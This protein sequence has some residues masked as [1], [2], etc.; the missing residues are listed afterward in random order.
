MDIQGDLYMFDEFQTSRKARTRRP[1]VSRAYMCTQCSHNVANLLQV[2][3]LYDV[4][5]NIRDDESEHV[6]TMRACQL[7]DKL[8]KRCDLKHAIW[9]LGMMYDAH[10]NFRECAS[11]PNSAAAYA[12]W[13]EEFEDGDD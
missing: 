10:T 9:I 5:C 1:E 12:Q 6:K 13:A 11:S 2:K 4:F 7:A 8:I 3:T